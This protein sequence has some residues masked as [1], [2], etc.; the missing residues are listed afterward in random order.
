[1]GMVSKERILSAIGA[2]LQALSGL[3]CK[4]ENLI[5]FAEMLGFSLRNV[6]Q[7][8]SHTIVMGGA[9]GWGETWPLHWQEARRFLNSEQVCEIEQAY[10]RIIEDFPKDLKQA[11]SNVFK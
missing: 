1:M 5:Q 4:Q 8:L 11:H 7:G 2:N 6:D 3:R 9:T 10:S